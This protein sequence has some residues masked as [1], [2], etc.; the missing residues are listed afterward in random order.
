MIVPISMVRDRPSHLRPWAW[1][2]AGEQDTESPESSPQRPHLPTW[3]HKPSLLLLLLGLLLDLL[4]F[5]G[6]VVLGS[7][8]THTSPPPISGLRWFCLLSH[9][10]TPS[11]QVHV[12]LLLNALDE[13]TLWICMTTTL[14]RYLSSTFSLWGNRD[15]ERLNRSR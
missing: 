2:S 8:V 5:E 12:P 7:F 3:L 6:A 11:M 15:T 9:S 1:D 10:H 13:I 4:F 14:Y